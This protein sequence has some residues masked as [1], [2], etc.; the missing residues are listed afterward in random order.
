MLRVLLRRFGCGAFK[1][2]TV[3]MNL[4]Q[5]ICLWIGI[6][7]IVL[8]GFYPPWVLPYNVKGV[9][10]RINAGYKPILKPP[11]RETKDGEFKFGTSIDFSRL[12]VQWVL[13]AIVTGGLLI[14]F[15]DK[16]QKDV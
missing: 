3:T 6:G 16:K 1:Q 5:K 11:I 4:K 14:T 8:M 10:N 7:L 9:K 12:G 2:K 15:K 13:V